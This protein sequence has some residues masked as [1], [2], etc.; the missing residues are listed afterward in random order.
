M[1]GLRIFLRILF[2]T[3]IPPVPLPTL[4]VPIHCPWNPL[5]GRLKGTKNLALQSFPW[6]SEKLS[7]SLSTLISSLSFLPILLF[8][9]SHCKI[10]FTC[11]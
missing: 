8:L 1:H 9:L 4:A 7:L 10:N 3:P 2:S 5:Q 11:K 6:F